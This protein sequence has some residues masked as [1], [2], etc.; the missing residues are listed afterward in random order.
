MEGKT[1]HMQ[2]NQHSRKERKTSHEVVI[3]LS[4]AC[5]HCAAVVA[6]GTQILYK[7]VIFTKGIKSNCIHLFCKK[8]CQCQ[9]SEIW[10]MEVKSGEVIFLVQQK[11]KTSCQEECR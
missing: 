9:Q 3:C 6:I 11:K 5:A 10:D 2:Q 1:K 4:P 7:K 8:Y